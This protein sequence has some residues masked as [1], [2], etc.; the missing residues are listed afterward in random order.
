M[1]LVPIL[2]KPS[3]TVINS[4]TGLAVFT[5]DSLCRKLEPCRLARIGYALLTGGC[6]INSRFPGTTLASYL[7]SSQQGD[8]GWSDVEETL[9]CL[10]YLTAFGDTYN[11]EISNGSRWLESVRLQCGAWGKS[12]RDQPRVPITALASCVIPEVVNKASLKWLAQQWEADLNSQT[13]LAYKGSYFLLASAHGEAYYNSELINRTIE[14]LISEQEEDGG[15]GPWKGHPVGSD[16]W[17]T[18]IVLWGLSVVGAQAPRSTIE[19][20]VSWLES[21]QLSNGLWPYH[22]IDDGTAMALIG[23]SSVLPLLSER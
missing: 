19:R 4:V 22:Y 15:Y 16:P 1:D 17:C 11:S 9:W 21:R 13:Q 14:Y 2:Q 20:A 23:I 8:G 12:Q 7:V 3:R 18:G 10:A 6:S 5:L